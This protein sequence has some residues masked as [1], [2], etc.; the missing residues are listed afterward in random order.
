MQLPIRRSH[1]L[2]AATILVIS[3]PSPAQT[4]DPAVGTWVLNV[5]KSKYN[6]GPPPK[7]LTVTFKPSSAGGMTVVSESVDAT[8]G[9]VRTEYTANY[10]GKDYPL[11]GV[12]IADVVSLKRIDARSSERTDK[13]SGRVVQTFARS[14]SPDGRTMTVTHKGTG[15]DGKPFTNTLVLVKK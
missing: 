14:V 6:S 13:R 5:A 3:G 8:G 15:A 4:Q 12:P 7:S 10:D 2:V 9:T 1:L 11:K